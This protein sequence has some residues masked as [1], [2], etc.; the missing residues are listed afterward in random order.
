M[1]CE[2]S[3]MSFVVSFYF[4]KEFE[5]DSISYSKWNTKKTKFNAFLVVNSYKDVIKELLSDYLDDV[6][7]FHHLRD[8]KVEVEMEDDMYHA[9][10]MMLFEINSGDFTNYVSALN[11]QQAEMAYQRM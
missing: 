2:Y 10:R 11:E 8:V 6:L 3:G 9:K 4:R 7:N 5:I 1:D